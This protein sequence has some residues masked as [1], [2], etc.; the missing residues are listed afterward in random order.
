VNIALSILDTSPVP[1][2]STAAQA[3][4]NTVTLAQEAD[5]LGYTRYWLA[6]HHNYAGAASAVPEIMIGHV[7]RETERIRV[8]AGGIML[9]N[10]APLKVAETFRLL[11]TLYPGRID[12]GIGRAPG[13]DPVTAF[14][15]RRSPAAVNAD[16]FPDLLA[17]LLAF[18]E[19]GFPDAHPFHTVAAIPSETALP[20]LFLLGSSDFGA[21]VAASLGVGFAFASHINPHGAADILRLYRERF[22]QTGRTEGPHAI[23]TAS[24]VCAETDERAD[25]LA[26]SIDLAFLKLRSGRAGKLP[27]PEE[28]SS[29]PYTEPEKMQ[30]RTGRAHHIVGSVATVMS[31]LDDMVERSGA[32]EVMILTMIHSHAD[33]IRSYQLLAEAYALHA[34][35]RVAVPA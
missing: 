30:V 27:S 26:S 17:E 18:S 5:R 23:L 8:G 35:E 3:L 28:V 11:E 32:D 15:L 14:A 13:T 33:R 10:H 12:L 22:V 24:V 7:A 9:P 6:E 34:D 20:P 21:Q 4:R 31:R 1:T 29:Y 25:Y 19:N 2:G 16:E